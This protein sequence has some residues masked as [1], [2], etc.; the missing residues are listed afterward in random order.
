[1]RMY[2][3]QLR[4]AAYAALRVAYAQCTLKWRIWTELA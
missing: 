2:F 3:V 1:L 4:I